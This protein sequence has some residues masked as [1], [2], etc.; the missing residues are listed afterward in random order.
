MA[1][2]LHRL[3]YVR[4]GHLVSVTRDDLV[5]QYIGHTAP[6]TKEV[7]KKAMGGVLFID[8]AYYLY[9]PDNERDYG[10]EAIEILLAGDGEPARR[11]GRHPRRL[12]RP[13]GQVLPSQPRLPLAHRPPHRIPR[14]QR[15]GAAGDRRYDAGEQNIAST[16][17]ARDAPWPYIADAPGRSRISPMRARSA[18]R[19]TARGCARPTACSTAKGP[20]S[21]SELSTISADDIRASQ[22]SSAANSKH[23][24]TRMSRN[25]LIAPSILSAD[26]ARF[27]EEVRAVDEAGCDWMH[28]DV[29]DGHFVPNITFGAPR[30][31]LR[32]RTQTVLDCHLMIEP[33]DP[34]RSL[35]QG[36]LRHHH[37]P[38]R[39]HQASRPHAAGH[40]RARQEGR[41]LAQSPNPGNVPSN[42]CWTGSTS[43]W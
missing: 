28:L 32:P 17:D 6:K 12:C 3:G 14:L 33:V 36:R 20:L 27:G 39:G 42:M 34:S 35:R 41:R 25:V 26:F 11:P 29:M 37:D 40:P 1:G 19:S 38:R 15:R 43:S 2:L 18:T 7:L 9:Q 13:H 21:A 16:P 10:Q 23:I 24:G 22:V 4:K 31:V 30:Q 5:G 8:E